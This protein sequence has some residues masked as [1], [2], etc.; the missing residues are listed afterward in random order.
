MTYLQLRS[1]DLSANDLTDV[2]QLNMLKDLQKLD[3]SA[4]KCVCGCMGLWV[5]ECMDERMYGRVDEW[6]YERVV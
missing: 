3:L 1:L 2:T 6:V 5:Y 4:N